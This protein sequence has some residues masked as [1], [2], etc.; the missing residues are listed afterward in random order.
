M[1]I[2]AVF[3]IIY[4]LWAFLFVGIVWIMGKVGVI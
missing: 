2:F 3:L 1:D 4:G